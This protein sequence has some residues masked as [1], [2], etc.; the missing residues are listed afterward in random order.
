MS[1]N[2]L[3]LKNFNI[4]IFISLF[5]V[6]YMYAASTLLI[7]SVY[8]IY[9]TII[10]LYMY[11]IFRYI[12]SIFIKITSVLF[13][14]GYVLS[15]PII[16]MNKE[17]YKVSG[18]NAV[19][20]FS[21][22]LDGL[23][24]VL[25]QIIFYF[26]IFLIVSLFLDKLLN[27][28][29]S[30]RKNNNTRIS[31]FELNN[32]LIY[33]CL[34]LII[35]QFPL[36]SFMFQHAIGIVGIT[37][38][39]LPFHLSGILYYYRLFI[40]PIVMFITIYG[41][42]SKKYSLL[43]VLIIFLEAFY[44]GMLSVSRSLL[45]IHMFPVVY[46]FFSKKNKFLL[47]TVIIFTLLFFSMVSM[48]R[49]YVYLIDGFN[50]SNLFDILSSLFN[51]NSIDW[52][53]LS[54]SSIFSIITRLG[55]IGQFIPTYFNTYNIN[56]VGYTYFIENLLGLHSL[57]QNN[58]DEVKIIYGMTF[59]DDKAYGVA[60]DTFS[61]IYL[62]SL[63]INSIII[64]FLLFCTLGIVGEKIFKIILIPFI[65]ENNFIILFH[66]LIVFSIPNQ[67]IKFFLFKGV[68]IL[69]FMYLIMSVLLFKKFKYKVNYR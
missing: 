32:L 17:K 26:T 16:Y 55:G 11:I 5:F 61:Y 51:D 13:Y 44:S 30:Y 14:I 69:F 41:T 38:D 68:F 59:P 15:L 57:F 23:L 22:S 50:Q 25:S 28:K 37:P 29:Y 1:L 39:T 19:G 42:M 36:T 2:T 6:M 27:L 24:I 12:D 7:T 9:M 48:G 4:L 33:L 21:F 60:M 62:S 49:N 40:L 31:T 56:F 53:S 58:F 46:Y 34:F 63:S 45:I 10:L 8:M 43:I 52:L 3:Y 54:S 20:N 67:Y 47:I 18:W 65:N 64:N 35:M 66:M